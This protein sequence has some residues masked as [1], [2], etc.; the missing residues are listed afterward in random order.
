[1]KKNEWMDD[2]FTQTARRHVLVRMQIEYDVHTIIVWLYANW[3][4]SIDNCIALMSKSA[5][6]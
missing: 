3:N 6:K 1:M 2:I 5:I 4:D